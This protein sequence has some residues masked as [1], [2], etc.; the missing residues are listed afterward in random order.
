MGQLRMQAVGEDRPAVPLVGRFG[1]VGYALDADDLG[2][3][4][5]KSGTILVPPCLV[6]ASQADRTRLSRS[7]LKSLCA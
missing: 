3:A 5:T 4:S 6:M 7:S 2:R 1:N